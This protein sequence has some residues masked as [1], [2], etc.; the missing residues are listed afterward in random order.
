MGPSALDPPTD[1]AEVLLLLLLLC[2]CVCLCVSVHVCV[3]V[4]LLV[5]NPLA[6]SP[7]VE[8]RLLDV[9]PTIKR[10]KVRGQMEGLTVAGKEQQV[11]FKEDVM[12]VNG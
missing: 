5:C 3:C 2:V 7:Q 11:C 12:C 6:T 4:C 8:H 9:L 1:L 10:R